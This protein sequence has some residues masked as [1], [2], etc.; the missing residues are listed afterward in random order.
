MPVILSSAKP[1][2]HLSAG[3]LNDIKSKR[4]WP[5]VE[6]CA[7]KAKKK[8]NN[9]QLSTFPSTNQPIKMPGN[10]VV[11]SSSVGSI[12]AKRKSVIRY[13]LS[14]LSRRSGIDSGRRI[15]LVLI[16]IHTY[17]HTWKDDGLDKSNIRP[18]GI[19]IIITNNIRPSAGREFVFVLLDFP[20]Y[21]TDY[22]L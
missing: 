11:N 12:G 10:R 17:I 1:S 21:S 2:V 3:R 8:T 13:V 9:K 16:Y 19:W 18:F 14:L 15:L 22:K 6:R 7:E 5:S 20:I 4:R